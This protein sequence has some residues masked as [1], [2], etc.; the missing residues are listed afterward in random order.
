MKPFIP[1]LVFL[2]CIAFFAF[3]RKSGGR[4]GQAIRESD[5][6]AWRYA[7]DEKEAELRALRA[8]EPRRGPTVN[9]D[10]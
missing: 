7:V 1:F 8:A 9:G 2:G 3:A 6:Q 4:L 10:A 5:W